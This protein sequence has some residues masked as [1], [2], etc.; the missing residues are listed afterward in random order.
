M[1][2]L[3][4]PNILRQGVYFMALG[5]LIGLA[6]IIETIF[7][8]LLIRIN[9]LDTNSIFGTL[10]YEFFILF[11]GFFVAYFIGAVPA[12]ITGVIS[13]IG[14]NRKQQ[15]IYAVL[16]GGLT[17][18][19]LVL[20]VFIDRYHANPIRILIVAVA[21]GFFGGFCAF[22]CIFLRLRLVTQPRLPKY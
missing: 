9:W 3:S 22:I 13:S 8:F 18:S 14:K 4:I 10:F 1:Q 12:F 6:I 11:Y 15:I 16:S 7:G 20:V 17:C 2:Q 19:L 5:P 21:S